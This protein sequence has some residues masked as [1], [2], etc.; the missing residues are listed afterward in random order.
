MQNDREHQNSFSRVYPCISQFMTIPVF[1]GPPGKKGF[2]RPKPNPGFRHLKPINYRFN[3]TVINTLGNYLSLFE[4]KIVLN[5]QRLSK[6][7]LFFQL[8]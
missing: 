3:L 1:P 7:G 6:T 4:R 8:F 2:G 5:V